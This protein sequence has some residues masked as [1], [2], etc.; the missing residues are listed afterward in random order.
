MKL[1]LR[2]LQALLQENGI[3]INF[4]GRFTQEIIEEL[5]DAV[6]RYLETENTPQSY[7]YN[8]FAVFIEQTQNIKNYG[9]AKEDTELGERIAA[10]GIVAIGKSKE[11]YFV[12]SGNLIESS[13]AKK[14]TASLDA[15]AQLDKAQLKKLFKERMRQE[16]PPGAQSAGIGL[17]DMARR[18]AKPLEYAVMQIDG[19]LAFFTLKVYV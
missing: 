5:G 16:V 1:G 15:L 2:D 13:D 14:L 17:I 3:L 8:V 6:K 18:S 11:G 12:S 19:I 4:S 9:R 7:T 10:S